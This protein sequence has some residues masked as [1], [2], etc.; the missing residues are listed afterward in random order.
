ML[1][2]ETYF[3]KLFKRSAVCGLT[4]AGF[5]CAY[6]QA[7][8]QVRLGGERASR[9]MERIDA[10]E[11]AQRWLHFGDNASKA[12]FVLSLSW[13][14][15]RAEAVRFLTQESCGAHGM[16]RGRSRA[17]AFPQFGQKMANL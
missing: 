6:S 4:V 17:S 10:E 7:T 15:N 14:I 11:G 9:F 5:F 12:T 3:L 13:R 8:A 2:R 16:S 1:F